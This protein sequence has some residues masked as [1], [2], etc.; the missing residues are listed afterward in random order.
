M[1]T[2]SKKGILFT[3]GGTAGHVTP[4]I[5]LIE[6]L[7]NENFKID[8]IGSSTGI[9]KKLIEEL[10]IPYYGIATGKLRRH[11][12]F[13]HFIEPF[14]IVWGIIQSYFILGKL[15]P[16]VVFSKGGFVSFPV[17]LTAWLRK[18]PV[19]SHESDMTP[20]LA[21]RLAFPFVRKL[22]INF[23]QTIKYFKDSSR[24]YVTGTPV[25]KALLSGDALKGFELTH[26]EH[27]KPVIMVIGGSL[28]AR[29]INET[30]RKAL[31]KLLTQYQIIHVCGKGN[32]DS[33][34]EQTIGYKQFEFVGIELGHLFAMSDM[35]ISRSGANALYELLTL[36]K[37]HLLIP[38][39]KQASRGDQ[40]HNAEHFVKQGVSHMLLEEDLTVDKLIDE[41]HLVLKNKD[42]TQ[43]QIKSLGFSSATNQVK[44]VIISCMA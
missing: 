3:G 33:S 25:R 2:P 24:V 17:V 23:P 19:V 39:S 36:N 8:Y 20:G 30:V 31:P 18:I 12:S 42:S 16:S 28:G 7:A 4:N 22:C 38:L 29:K 14:K 32:L 34:L 5:A 15:K 1:N 11:W 10:N 35:V 6:V 43:Q 13:K 9:E 41:V 27:N 26:F 21:N 40:I 37:P 44:D